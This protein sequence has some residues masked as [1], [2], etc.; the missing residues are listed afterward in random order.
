[1]DIDDQNRTGLSSLASHVKIDMPPS[2][3]AAAGNTVRRMAAIMHPANLEIPVFVNSYSPRLSGHI[4][5]FQFFFLHHGR[6]ADGD[7][8]F[9]PRD[10]AHCGASLMLPHHVEAGFSPNVKGS[11]RRRTLI[12]G[13][14]SR[15]LNPVHPGDWLR[16]PAQGRPPRYNYLLEDEFLTEPALAIVYCWESFTWRI[17]NPDRVFF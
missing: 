7:V 11:S 4:L 5:Y 3:V 10:I 12:A 9:L 17:D 2:T 15:T 1:V 14:T 13:R 8:R 6:D 16:N